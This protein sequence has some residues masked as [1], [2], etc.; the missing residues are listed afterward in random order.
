MATDFSKV[1]GAGSI[2]VDLPA[3]LENPLAVSHDFRKPTGSVPATLENPRTGHIIPIVN[4][5]HKKIIAK[6]T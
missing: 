4:I 2:N 6:T 3:I 5:I 1:T